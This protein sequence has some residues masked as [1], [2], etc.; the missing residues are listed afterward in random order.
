MLSGAAQGK[1]TASGLLRPTSVKAPV[2]NFK[3]PA[4]K[5]TGKGKDGKGKDG[6]SKD[7]TLL[8]Q[9]AAI[10]A[11]LKVWVGGVAETAT[12]K[13]LQKHFTDMDCKPKI[14]AI[15]GKGGKACVSFATAEAAELAIA[16]VNMTELEGSMLEVDVWTQK[17]ASKSSGK[18]SAKGAGNAIKAAAKGAGNGFSV[19]RTLDGTKGKGKGK[20]KQGKASRPISAAGEKL[21]ATDN[22]LK[23]WVGGLVE[24]TTAEQ[25]DAH[26]K[27]SGLMPEVVDVLKRGQA[28]AGFQ[29]IEDVAN[30]I[31]VLNGSVL[32]DKA[33]ELDVWEKPAGK[34]V[35]AGKGTAA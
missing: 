9:L 11:S 7:N 12:W 21:K 13:S 20:S 18:G 30:A 25:V 34:G 8:D 16:M 15:L 4:E 32:N 29:T 26:F 28:C 31:A 1:G 24:G 23:V 35:A 14:C 6:K 17:P 5:G 19:M 2:V 22:T 10:D 3:G 27:E 33:I